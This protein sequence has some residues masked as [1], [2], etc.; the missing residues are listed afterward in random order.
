[1][2]LTSLA[3]PGLLHRPGDRHS[4][5]PSAPVASST[6][7]LSLGYSGVPRRCPARP[8]N[9]RQRGRRQCQPGLRLLPHLG[10]PV[11][12]PDGTARGRGGSASGA[13]RRGGHAPTAVAADLRVG[14]RHRTLR[15]NHPQGRTVRHLLDRDHLAAAAVP[16]PPLRQDPIPCR[17]GARR[18]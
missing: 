18:R 9:S 2:P 16:R 7:E 12:H 1:L 13:G 8:G 11:G 15:E 17:D 4:H 10:L 3:V 5:S 14:L 6:Q